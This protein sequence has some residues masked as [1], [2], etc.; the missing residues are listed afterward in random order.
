MSSGTGAHDPSAP[1][2]G[3]TSWGT[4]PAS[5]GRRMNGA[6]ACECLRL[7]GKKNGAHGNCGSP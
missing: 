4:S 1:D 2:Y 5:L 6:P 3:G 7:G